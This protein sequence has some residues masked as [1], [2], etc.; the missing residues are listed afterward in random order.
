[1]LEW[2][3]S[4]E[5]ASAGFLIPAFEFG[6]VGQAYHFVQ[7]TIN[8]NLAQHV[9]SDTFGLWKLL[10]HAYR[11]GA[12]GRFGTALTVRNGLGCR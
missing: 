2:F 4:S 5:P 6:T 1:M 3:D 9:T 11:K 8:Q 10:D 12:R 7:K